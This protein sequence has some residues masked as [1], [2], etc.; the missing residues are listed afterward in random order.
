MVGVPC[1]KEM[2]HLAWGQGARPAAPSFHAQLGWPAAPSP[3]PAGRSIDPR[4]PVDAGAPSRSRA[5]WSM[6]AGRPIDASLCTLHRIRRIG[7]PDPRAET[8]LSARFLDILSSPARIGSDSGRS[9]PIWPVW[10][11]SRIGG[12][13]VDSRPRGREDRPWGAREAAWS[14]LPRVGGRAPAAL[15]PEPGAQKPPEHWAP[16]APCRWGGR[17]TCSAPPSRLPG[18]RGRPGGCAGSPTPASPGPTARGRR[19][20]SP[21]RRAGCRSGA[22]WRWPGQRRAG[23]SP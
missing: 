23:A 16:G 5:G 7:L 14:Q 3:S 4:G 19:A 11:G 22:S 2:P 15:S 20:P 18:A 6:I 17:A 10:W 12:W 13:R 9:R 21:R 1:L 8:A